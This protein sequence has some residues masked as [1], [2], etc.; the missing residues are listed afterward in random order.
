METT[1]QNHQPLFLK[2]L[3][4]QIEENLSD[5]TLDMKRVTRL[6]GMS[7]TDLH[8]KL[9]SAIGMST[10]EYI[11]Y[12]RLHKAADLLLLEPEWSVYH[13][14]LEVG[15]NNQSYFTR[16]FKALFGKCPT[17]FRLEN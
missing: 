12:V 11:R 13:I 16:R 15:F 7:R 14:S 8:R 2:T 10:T 9:Y 4:C 5:Y 1:R 17:T 3:N 6:V